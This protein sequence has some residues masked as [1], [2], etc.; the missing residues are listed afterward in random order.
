[1]ASGSLAGSFWKNGCGRMRQS[2]RAAT[3]VSRWLANVM[4]DDESPTLSEIA[5][6]VAALF[7]IGVVAG[8]VVLLG[9]VLL[10][11]LGG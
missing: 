2:T 11:A 4:D 5:I 6:T 8:I 10:R 3:G 1:M 7:F 9:D